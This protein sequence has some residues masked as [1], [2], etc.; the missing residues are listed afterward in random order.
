M[1]GAW[2]PALLLL[3]TG[4]E[5]SGFRDAYLSLDSAGKRER[6]RFFTDTEGIFCIGKMASGVEDVTV[7]A[8]LRAEQIYDPRTGR[9]VDVDYDLGLSEVAPGKGEDITVSFE[10]ERP[11]ADAPFTAGRFVCELSLDGELQERLPFEVSFPDCPAAPLYSGAAC[12]G[13]VLPGSRCDG[14]LGAPCVCRDNGSWSC[15]Q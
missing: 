13:F 8:R 7:R 4:C 3:T 11:D 14:A 12:A 1:K 10:F 6:E 15:E 5:T 9:A 2:L